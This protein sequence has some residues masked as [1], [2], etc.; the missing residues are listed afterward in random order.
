MVAVG[1]AAVY[2]LPPAAFAIV[3]AIVLPGL[4][5]WEGA[6]LAG[7]AHPIARLLFTLALLL[8]ALAIHLNAGILP[9]A[10]LLAAACVVWLVNFG[11]LTGPDLG[12]R[13]TVLSTLIKLAALAVAMLGAWLALVWLQAAS[14]WLVLLVFIIIAAADIGAYFTGKH[15]GGA[16]LAPRISPGKT[17]AGAFGGLAGATLVTP[18]AL[19]FLPVAPFAWLLAGT[20]A[21]ALALISIGGDLFISLLKR[22]CGIKDTSALLPGHGGVLDR[23]DGVSAALPFFALAVMFLGGRF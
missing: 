5:G 3:A 1:L 2:L 11:W 16:R 13:R 15:F 8:S 22:Q 7:L 20:L 21:F 23:F 17:W 19:V 18:L 6:R 10:W 12:R 9:V 4:G 14:P